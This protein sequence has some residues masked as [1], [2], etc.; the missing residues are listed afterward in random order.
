MA[1]GSEDQAPARGRS[2]RSARQPMPSAAAR[3]PHPAR[4]G[5]QVT[6]SAPLHFARHTDHTNSAR[7]SSVTRLMGVSSLEKLDRCCLPCRSTWAPTPARAARV[8]RADRSMHTRLE[9]LRKDPLL[10]RRRAALVFSSPFMLTPRILC[11][12]GGS[13]IVGWSYIHYAQPPSN[14]DGTRRIAGRE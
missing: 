5:D 4:T 6:C 10:I 3:R 1:R 7:W 12:D 2:D 13:Y 14:R 11:V 9:D 8:S